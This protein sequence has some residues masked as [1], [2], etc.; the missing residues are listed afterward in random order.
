MWHNIVYQDR[1]FSL[2]LGLPCGATDDLTEYESTVKPG[3]QGSSWLHL[4]LQHSKVVKRLLNRGKVKDADGDVEELDRMLLTAAKSVPDNFWVSP[5]FEEP[6]DGQSTFWRTIRAMNQVKHYSLLNCL[7]LP[8]LLREDSESKYE[9]SKVACLM[10]S[11][12]ILRRYNSYRGAK[13][14]LSCC[15]PLDFVALLAA[16]TVMVAHMNSHRP[17]VTYS[18]LSHQRPSDRTLIQ[19]VLK[20]MDCVA[21]LNDDQMTYQSACLLRRLMHIEADAKAGHSYLTEEV[22]SADDSG[23]KD[24]CTMDKC[25]VLHID[26][27][28]FGTLRISR[29]A[30]KESAQGSDQQA[31][32]NRLNMTSEPSDTSQPPAAPYF[33]SSGQIDFTLQMDGQGGLDLLQQM[34]YPDPTATVDDWAFQGKFMTVSL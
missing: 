21:Q 4:E 2:L 13:P 30:V 14:A 32:A 24:R 3:L 18:F 9:H 5:N 33:A 25:S 19:Q 11:R 28:Y 17:K 8:Y 34:S 26:I 1:Y 27:P 23:A 10:A 16:L 7:H 15:R 6:D 22:E 20:T 12:E 31:A 29:A